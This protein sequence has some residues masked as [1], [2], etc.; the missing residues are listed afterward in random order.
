MRVPGVAVPGDDPQHAR[1]VCAKRQGWPRP[2]NGA[3]PKRGIAQTVVSAL[4]ACELVAEQAVHDLEGL[5]E[6]VDQLTPPWEGQPVHLMLWLVPACP[7]S[8]LEPS[9]RDV[10]HSDGLFGQECGVTERVAAHKGADADALGARRQGRE[11]RPG[12]EVWTVRPA[13]L[14]EVVAV[15]GAVEAEALEELPALARLGPGHVLVCTQSEA[16]PP[17]HPAALHYAPAAFPAA[18]RAV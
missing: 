10:V 17:R 8:Q 9:A 4:M 18:L 3:G 14:N 15:P 11:Q 16:K 13:R 7:E 6:A 12:L 2:L 5:F 1:A